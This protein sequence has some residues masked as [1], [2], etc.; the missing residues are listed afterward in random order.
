[1]SASRAAE[2]VVGESGRIDPREG[3]SLYYSLLWTDD[4]VRERLLARLSL[5]HAL[6]TTLEEVQEPGVA[7]RKVHWWHEE[8]ERLGRGAPRH[9]RTLACVDSLGGVPEA[10]SACLELLS[11]AAATRYSPPA[12]ELDL[13]AGLERGGRAALSLLAH[14]LSGEPADLGADADVRHPA[15][16]LGLGLHA[17]LARLPRLLHRG[18]AVFSDE[19]YA[20]HR[21]SPAD[22]AGHVRRRKD[23]PRE[24]DETRPL[25]PTLGGVPVVVDASASRRVLIAEVVDE[26]SDTLQAA[27]ADADYRRVYRRAELAPV[28]RLAAL[29]ARQLALW[30]DT[31]PDLLRERT[32]LT[33]LVKLYVAWRHRRGAR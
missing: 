16:A 4:A 6:L 30:K 9:P 32:A 28:A 26:A 3:S 2:G 17:T 21:L 25:A 8:L 18:H 29:R 5:I 7:E 13:I 23:T 19:R 1:M 12:T 27:L 10:E 14:A 22:L 24:S 33:P 31:R 11:F 15:L 20:R